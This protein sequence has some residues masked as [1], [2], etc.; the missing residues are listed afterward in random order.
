MQIQT[1]LEKNVGGML[2]PAY[3][4]A[5]LGEDLSINPLEALA[6]AVKKYHC[7]GAVVHPGSVSSINLFNCEKIISVIDFPYGCGRLT[8]KKLEARW[9]QMGG[10]ASL[11]GVDVVLNLWALQ[12]QNWRL[13]KTEI[14]SVKDECPGKEIKVI[15]QMP[16]VWQ[17]HRDLIP[18]LLM[19]LNECGVNV[20]KDWTTVNNFS[21]PIKIDT[22]TRLEYI[23][24][25]RKTID[26][27]RYPL[28]I[29]AAGGIDQN[30]IVLFKEAGADIFGVGLQKLPSV[31]DVLVKHFSSK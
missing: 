31:F 4:Y 30:N 18:H 1:D 7:R 6:R 22:E 27:C 14:K 23:K 11:I 25:L 9:V 15:C 20:V 29:K 2:E 10:G 26:E 19:V 16:F 12:T 5:D 3:L 17:Y 13:I 21:R 8:G 28:L 24:Y